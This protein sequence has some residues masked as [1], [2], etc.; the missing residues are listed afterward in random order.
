[1][2]RRT[3]YLDSIKQQKPTTP[4]TPSVQVPPS[5]TTTPTPDLLPAAPMMAVSEKG[6]IHVFF[7]H[8]LG[9]LVELELDQLQHSISLKALKKA[10][11]VPDEFQKTK[12]FKFNK[13]K[14]N[15]VMQNY[16]EN[17]KLVVEKHFLVLPDSTNMEENSIKRKEY[18]TCFGILLEFIFKKKMVRS[19]HLKPRLHWEIGFRFYKV[20][21]KNEKLN[22]QKLQTKS[23]NSI[24]KVKILKLLM[25][26]L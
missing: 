11:L 20:R 13:G 2:E 18:Q 3:A 8:D 23:P 15:G 1:V 12:L 19:S 9:T 25:M 14:W 17:N 6:T 24:M 21:S 22:T 4:E 5:P 10:Y 16:Q 26:I 7:R